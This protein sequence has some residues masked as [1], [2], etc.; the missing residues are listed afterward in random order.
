M[1]RTNPAHPY[2]HTFTLNGQPQQRAWF[3]HSEIAHGGR[4][5]LTMAATPHPTFATD[6]KA[7]P[8]SLTL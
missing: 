5:Q 8:P 1:K 3:H 6:P 7:A 2:I 4:I